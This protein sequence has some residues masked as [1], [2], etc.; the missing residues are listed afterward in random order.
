MVGRSLAKGKRAHARNDCS[1]GARVTDCSA[2]MLAGSPSPLMATTASYEPMTPVSD[3]LDGVSNSHTPSISPWSTER[4]TASDIGGIG[5]ASTTTS[6]DPSM[7][8]STANVASG[9]TDPGSIG[10]IHPND[11]LAFSSMHPVGISDPMR[12]SDID[13][14]TNPEQGMLDA[15]FEL[16]FSQYCLPDI[17]HNA[18][19]PSN[20]HQIASAD[21][22]TASAA[23]HTQDKVHDARPILPPKVT[24]LL[25]SFDQPGLLDK[26]PH[27]SSLAK[28]I[29][30][31]EELILNHATTIDKVLR[32][33]KFC[34]SVISGITQADYFQNCKC[35]SMLILTAMDLVITLYEAGVSE[36]LR[37]SSQ[38]GKVLST[39]KNAAQEASLQFGVFQFEPEDHTMFRNQ[40]VRN[41]LQRC[42]R[43]VQDQSGELRSSTKDASAPSH[44]LHQNWLSVI[45]NRARLLTSSLKSTDV[46]I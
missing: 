29:G 23:A 43:M 13:Q 24:E 28:I 11:S 10:P 12:D 33:N 38:P 16:D 14:C 3:G 36:Y 32:S 40:I 42:I 22:S 39:E 34:M 30:L 37:S 8:T 20:A 31:L 17:L 45:E 44:K 6:L 25:E 46:G 15:D 21:A 2:L 27:V 19:D 1:E 4:T 41:E 18:P 7:P 35:C 9:S 5:R 26:F